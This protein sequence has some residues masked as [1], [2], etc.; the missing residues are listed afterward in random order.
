M[1]DGKIVVVLDLEFDTITLDNFY[2]IHVHR[3]EVG[4]DHVMCDKEETIALNGEDVFSVSHDGE[5]SLVF[6]NDY[7]KAT[8]AEQMYQYMLSMVYDNGDGTCN[9]HRFL[10]GAYPKAN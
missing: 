10:L 8:E 3:T 7:F 2:E 5:V 6:Q 9:T 4:Y 1:E